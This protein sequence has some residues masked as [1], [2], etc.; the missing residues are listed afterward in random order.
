MGSSNGDD[1][2][3]VREDIVFGNSK[4]EV[5]NIEEFTFYPTNITLAKNTSAKCPM[6]VLESGV[7]QVLRWKESAIRFVE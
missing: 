7:I 6:N 4:L 2:A 5:K 1:S 3:M